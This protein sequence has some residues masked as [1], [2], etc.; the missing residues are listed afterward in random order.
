VSSPTEQESTPERSTR[1]EP[2]GVPELGEGSATPPR[3]P[4]PGR[5]A[6]DPARRRAARSEA[7][8]P[9]GAVLGEL[10]RGRPWASG[11]ALGKLGRRWPEVVGERL[12]M[13]CSPAALEGG[14]LLVE[15]G[16][17]AWAVQLR[18]L[19]REIEA[20]ANR[21]LG[22]TAVHAVRVAVRLPQEGGKGGS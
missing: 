1:G 21:V 10:T 11:V 16:S 8:H 3:R 5:S 14:L 18:F 12:A 4:A 22:W 20:R 9:L 19:A 15:A 6:P 2:T 13:E 7:I 17:G